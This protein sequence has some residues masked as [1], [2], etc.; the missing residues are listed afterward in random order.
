MRRRCPQETGAVAPRARPP[1]STD[2]FVAVGTSPGSRNFLQADPDGTAVERLSKES[3]HSHPPFSSCP[4]SRPRSDLCSLLP[5]RQ[6][7]L[8]DQSLEDRLADIL[9]T[10]STIKR[11]ARKPRSPRT[12]PDHSAPRT[13]AATRPSSY[14]FLG[15][16]LE[17]ETNEGHFP[18]EQGKGFAKAFLLPFTPHVLQVLRGIDSALRTKYA[19]GPF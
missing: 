15:N 17:S 14:C 19:D 13:I 18:F 6:C 2:E 7:E 16:F 1:I 9:H 3:N 12:C 10:L 11:S 5:Q 8:S 4:S